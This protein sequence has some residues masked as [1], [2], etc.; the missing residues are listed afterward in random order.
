MFVYIAMCT[1]K[2]G[3]AANYQG[4]Y[5]QMLMEGTRDV[6]PVLNFPSKRLILCVPVLVRAHALVH[7]CMCI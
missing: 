1:E 5:A 7:L 6:L 2:W 3:G 4:E